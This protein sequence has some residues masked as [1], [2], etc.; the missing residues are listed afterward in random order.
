MNTNM[1]GGD[2]STEKLVQSSIEMIESI[3]RSMIEL[4][5][6]LEAVKGATGFEK[7]ARDLE[8]SIETL[9]DRLNLLE[10]SN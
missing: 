4:S 7:E 8:I 6:R 5:K 9:N 10:K 3:S 2:M 1:E